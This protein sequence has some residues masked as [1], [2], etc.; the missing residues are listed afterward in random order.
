MTSATADHGSPMPDRTRPFAVPPGWVPLPTW[1][2]LAH[3]ARGLSLRDI[4]RSSGEAP[5]TICRRVRRIEARRDDPLFDEA[6]TPCWVRPCC[7][8]IP[9]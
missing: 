2:Y 9:N 4:A 6:L 5:S 7:L 1:Q 8:P 3:T